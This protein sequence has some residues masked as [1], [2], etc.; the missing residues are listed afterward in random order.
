MAPLPTPCRA[1]FAEVAACHR[2]G[3]FRYLQVPDDAPAQ[4]GPLLDAGTWILAQAATHVSR[5]Y[6][7]HLGSRGSP[8]AEEFVQRLRTALTVLRDAAAAG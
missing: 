4:I 2:P 8:T 3:G 7:D 6:V 1:A 5:H